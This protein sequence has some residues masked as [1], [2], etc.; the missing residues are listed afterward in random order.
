[1][2]L[3]AVITLTEVFVA[4]WVLHWISGRLKPLVNRLT[5]KL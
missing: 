4:A 1:M 2:W 3:E 5:A